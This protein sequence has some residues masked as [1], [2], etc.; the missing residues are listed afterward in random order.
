MRTSPRGLLVVG[1]LPF[2]GLCASQPPA[3]AMH[4]GMN[5]RPTAGGLRHNATHGKAPISGRDLDKWDLD[6]PRWVAAAAA[7][8]EATLTAKQEKEL[9]RA[10]PKLAPLQTGH[11]KDDDQMQRMTRELSLEELAYKWGTDKSRDDHKYVDMYAALVDPV[12]K[13]V[14][15][16]TELG[17]AAGQSVAMWAEYFPK[18]DVWGIDQHIG[19]TAR[20]VLGSWPSVHLLQANVYEVST[21]HA[22]GL[23]DGTMD[24]V[25]DDAMHGQAYNEVALAIFWRLVRPGGYYVI[26]D[27][28]YGGA[29]GALDFAEREPASEA[30]R[31]IFGSN[32]AFFV[33]ATLGHRNFSAWLSVAKEQWSRKQEKVGL[34]GRLRAAA[35]W[36]RGD[37][38]D[39]DGEVPYGLDRKRHNA[40]MVV[41]RKRTAPEQPFQMFFGKRAMEAE[42]LRRTAA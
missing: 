10:S 41:I 40:H 24:L 42:D 2:V 25:I 28:S 6:K 11:E 33:D 20:A 36:L 29:T 27:S 21:P 9:A 30:A 35:A 37:V 14:R 3:A 34:L 39:T 15:N 22:L 12:R 7:R 18:A 31:A 32:H 26:E 8:K 4:K 1:L 23:A 38:T 16:V 19:P 17:V 13:R 5:A